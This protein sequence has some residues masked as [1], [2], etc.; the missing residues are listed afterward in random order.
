M[1]RVLV[2]LLGVV[3]FLGLAP[4]RAWAQDQA[5]EDVSAATASTGSTSA[6]PAAST[7]TSSATGT[8]SDAH[9]HALATQAAAAA[10]AQ[11][12]AQEHARQPDLLEHLVDLILQVFHMPTAGNTP[13]HYAVSLLFLITA[14]L[15]R[16]IVTGIIF[17]QLKKL[18]ERTETTLD[19]K[20][21]P[22]LEAPTA[23]FVTVTGIFAALKV[24]K[25][26]PDADLLIDSGATV[27][28]ALA[29]FW[30][31]W[32]GLDAVL[33]HAHEIARHKD[34]GI[35]G[36]MP[37]IKKTLF[38]A[39]VVIGLLLTLKSLGFHVETW[40]AGLGI[41]GLA[42][43]LAAQDTLANV[44]GAIVVA[45]DQPFKV[46]EAVKIGG[47]IGIIEDIGLRSTRIRLL[48]K[49]LMVIPNKTVASETITNFSRFTRRRTEQV[50]GL[51]YDTTPDQ[52]TA[53]VDDLRKLLTTHAEVDAASVMVYFRDFNSSSLDIWVVYEMPNA[54]FLRGMQTRQQLNLAIMRVIADRGL[55]M[56]FPTQTIQ[57][58]GPIARQLAGRSTPGS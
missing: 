27:A 58:D 54:D 4:A 37:W 8:S 55:S 28:F 7:I 30:W 26:P 10:V 24:L 32:R 51:T 1:K 2:L 14:L 52:M 57:L 34:L 40:L 22:A 56:A 47:N 33:D 6:S 43:A 38:T 23:A 16:R 21:F 39:F 19:D 11:R 42:F 25:L 53:V 41:G 20:L 49:S 13:A 15:A 36:F 29:I 3:L 17:V 9:E 5:D 50:I 35:A 44:F 48:D 12:L 31:L 45:A 18:A 46:G